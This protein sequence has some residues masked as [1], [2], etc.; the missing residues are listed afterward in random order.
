MQCIAI[1]IHPWKSGHSL[2][3]AR[4]VL[5][6]F[7]E[8]ISV[9]DKLV[10]LD[11]LLYNTAI[12][13]SFSSHIL[14]LKESFHTC[15]PTRLLP[16][17]RSYVLW[18]FVLTAYCLKLFSWAA[19]NSAGWNQIPLWL[20]FAKSNLNVQVREE[21]RHCLFGRPNFQSCIPPPP[22]VPSSWGTEVRIKGKLFEHFE[23]ESGLILVPCQ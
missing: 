20:G 14:L 6:S 17:P 18:C 23:N 8:Y 4:E 19:V 2:I 9:W 11:I 21:H 22:C 5:F 15:W 7:R 3:S 10:A 13:A 16:A 1:K 12:D